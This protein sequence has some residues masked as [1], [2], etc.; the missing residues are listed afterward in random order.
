MISEKRPR[1]NG[2]TYVYDIRGNIL[3]K[4]QKMDMTAANNDAVDLVTK[5]VYDV[6]YRNA[7][8][9]TLPSGLKTAYTYDTKGNLTESKVVAATLNSGTTTDITI[10]NEYDTKGRLT[11]ST[12]P[13]GNISTYEY[14]TGSAITKITKGLRN[15]GAGLDATAARVI[16]YTYDTRENPLTTTDP[17][18]N[19]STFTYDAFDRLTSQLSAAGIRKNFVFSANNKIE[20]TITPLTESV[21]LT[22]ENTYDT[23]D[24]IIGTKLSSTP[25]DARNLV[26]V[27]D[28][29]ENIVSTT[30]P[31]GL[32]TKYTYDALE[33]V[34]E[35]RLV[36]VANDPTKD[37]VTR[38]EYDTNG[39]QIKITDPIGAITVLT[40]D[41]FDRPKTKT[42][43]L[44]TK[45]TYTYDTVGNITETR[46]ESATG[47]LL[48][49]TSVVFNSI[50]RLLTQSVWNLS[51]NTP[52]VQSYTYDKN[53]NILTLTDPRSGVTT[54]S[55]S[56]H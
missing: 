36:T 22:E 3:E 47:A 44:G 24:E 27:R 10:S 8:E 2:T 1:G 42:D 53:G 33:R 37:I 43:A 19:V 50:T 49:K 4:R 5:Y 52:I 38:Y 15:S 9:R 48:A 11:K 23:L 17:E 20:K 46:T 18:G 40:Y 51:T 55:Y 16:T 32:T 14:G 12:D 6:N 28:K 54:T 29:N 41:L 45:T 56:L 35:K 25:S 31:S 34:T 21:S 13:E 26:I 7:T 39:N 30:D